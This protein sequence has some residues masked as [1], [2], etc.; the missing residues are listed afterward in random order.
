M[1]EALSGLRQSTKPGR[2]K[3]GPRVHAEGRKDR[4]QVGSDR[5]VFDAKAVRDLFI[6]QATSDELNH[7]A[8][9]GGEFWQ[10]NDFGWQ[11]TQIV[12]QFGAVCDSLARGKRP[13]EVSSCAGML[14]P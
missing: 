13:P 3:A 11:G 5:P 6:S 10:P 4:F 2:H 12:D 1:T 8:L 14:R 9:P 7:L